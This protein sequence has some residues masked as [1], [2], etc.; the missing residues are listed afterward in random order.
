MNVS[1]SIPPPRP[2]ALERAARAD[3]MMS[4]CRLCAFDCGAD[5][6]RGP[7]GFCRSDATARA[8]RERIEWAGER[9]LVPN[10]VV[11]LSG[12]NMRCDFCITGEHSQNSASGRP[13]DLEALAGRVA[14]AAPRMRSFTIEGGEPTIHLP[15][16]LRIAAA[17]PT[18]LRLVWK[19][20]AYASREALDLL[21]GV[22]EVVL[23]DLKFGNDACAQRLAGI[24]RYTEVAR[25]NL[26]WARRN[27]SLIVRH[28]LM[29]G[30]LE[31][32]ALPVMDW[33]A[34]TM[35]EVPL[36]LM[37]AFLPVFR[38]GDHAELARL[39]RSEEVERAKAEAARRGLT[40]SPWS[41]ASGESPER[42]TD[43]IWIDRQGRVTL[44]LVTGELAACLERI[45]SELVIGA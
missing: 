4:D 26:R 45:S 39:N 18:E 40:L 24:P 13:V 32:C 8:F 25:E 30:H 11:N 23:A 12:C 19:T 17:V 44:G 2:L 5:R 3:A 33:L 1:Q 6:T 22:V 15:T 29:P 10:F 34:A 38:S 36:T 21:E 20:N 31:C 27:S 35:P 28:L 41:M 14:Q 7:A 37:G 42:L 16:A 43:E 9:E